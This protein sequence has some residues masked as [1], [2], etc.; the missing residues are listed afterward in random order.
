MRHP[1]QRLGRLRLTQRLRV[2]SSAVASPAGMTRSARTEAC[3][4]HLDETT[5][6][7][8]LAGPLAGP[9]A[10]EARLECDE[11]HDLAI[12]VMSPRRFPAIDRLRLERGDPGFGGNQFKTALSPIPPPS[13]RFGGQ[14]LGLAHHFLNSPT[15]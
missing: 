10:Q 11:S 15:M 13:G 2:K 9:G 1:S 6:N 8:M 7:D 14:P 12:T 5:D 4:G 3:I